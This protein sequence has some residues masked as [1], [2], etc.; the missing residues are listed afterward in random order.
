MSQAAHKN[1]LLHSSTPW[2]PRRIVLTP[3][4]GVNRYV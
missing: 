4:T 1:L 2:L 3:H